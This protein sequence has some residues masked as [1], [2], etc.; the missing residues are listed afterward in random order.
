MKQVSLFFFALFLLS[1]N[2]HAQLFGNQDKKMISNNLAQISLLKTYCD[3]LD[4]GLTIA[5]DGLDLTHSLKN[6]E[7]DLHS[8]FYSSLL[9]VN[10]NI[11]KYPLAGQIV[12]IYTKMGILQTATNNLTS[13]TDMLS[14]KEKHSLKTL[15]S[16]VMTATRKDMEELNNLLT[17]GKYQLTD[18]ERI[19]RIDAVY[20]RVL[21]KFW[22]LSNINK[23]VNTIVAGRINQKNNASKFRQLYGIP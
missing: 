9:Q 18:D 11:K 12:D 15:V 21:G 2:S 7:F 3:Y 6:G 10:P 13:S 16:N 23:R 8:L 4:K 19:K 5:H 20:K 1:P 17:D 14:I 22:S